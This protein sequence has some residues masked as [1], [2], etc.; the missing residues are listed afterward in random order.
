MSQPPVNI[1]ATDMYYITMFHQAIIQFG[2]GKSGNLE[3]IYKEC[4]KKVPKDIFM[5]GLMNHLASE[6]T[7]KEDTKDVLIE[8]PTTPSDI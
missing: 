1:Q 4:M 2:E 6:N 7:T 5:R 8:T 3:T